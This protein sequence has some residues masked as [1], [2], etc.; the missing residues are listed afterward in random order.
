MDDLIIT[1]NDN[2]YI[3]QLNLVFEM[4]DLGALHHFLGIEVIKTMDSLFLSQTKYAKDLLTCTSMLDC[5]PYGS[6]YNYKTTSSNTS[7]PPTT[8]PT[9][10]QS[11][12]GAL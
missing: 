9:L 11:V 3:T 4:K 12:T 10:Y 8:D 1:G 5:K 6:P 7:S 2:S